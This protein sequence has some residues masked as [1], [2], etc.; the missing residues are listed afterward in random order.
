MSSLVS[1]S[2]VITSSTLATVGLALFEAIV[3]FFTVGFTL[4]TMT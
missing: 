4:S 1:K 3:T 2:I